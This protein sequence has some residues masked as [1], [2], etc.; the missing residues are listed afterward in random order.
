MLI[1]TSRD[2]SSRLTAFAKE[3]KLLFPGAVRVNRGGQVVGDLVES[4]RTGGFS[5][6]VV[7]HEHRGEPDGM[8][9]SH[10]PFGAPLPAC[11]L[12]LCC[13]L[14]GGLFSGV[15]LAVLLRVARRL[16]AQS[17]PP[18]RCAGPTAYF[19]L[20]NCVMRHDIKDS[21]LGNMSEARVPA[22][23]AAA[24]AEPWC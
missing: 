4:S 9:I 7:V 20:M 12:R 6:I 14:P 16:A 17:S 8:V 19:G 10:L 1:T 5:D 13:S 18:G 23:A 2:P 24:K 21:T 15:R 11:G 3:L 22:T